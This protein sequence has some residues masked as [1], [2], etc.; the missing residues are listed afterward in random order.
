MCPILPARSFNTDVNSGCLYC[1]NQLR[2]ETT[3]TPHSAFV[4]FKRSEEYFY[5]VEGGQ[6]SKT[7]HKTPVQWTFLLIFC[8]WHGVVKFGTHPWKEMF[9]ESLKRKDWSRNKSELDRGVWSCVC[10]ICVWVCVLLLEVNRLTPA[11]SC[12]LVSWRISGCYIMRLIT[13]G[14][15]QDYIAS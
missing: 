6:S 11:A 15:E 8:W 4:P 7:K 3:M 10:V 5:T 14:S 2:G 13:C 9:E 12:C 1:C